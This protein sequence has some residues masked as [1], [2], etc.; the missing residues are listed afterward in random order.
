MEALSQEL[1]ELCSG[2][3]DNSDTD[4]LEPNPLMKE[5]FEVLQ[6]AEVNTTKATPRKKGSSI[7]G[8]SISAQFKTSLIML[9]RQ[10]NAGNPHYVRCIKPNRTKSPS[11]LHSRDV[12]RQLR[13]SGMMEAI[14]IRHEG[15]ALRMDH[16]DFLQEY[17]VLGMGCEDDHGGN[18]GV[19]III[20][21][22][23]IICI[24]L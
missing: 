24:D 1:K 18:M 7:R 22:V 9:N 20:S 19:F 2:N 23:I 4:P 15:Y 10:L 16:R 21:F 12:L 5:M 8:V 13:Y 3:Y 6:P 11:T 17:R 14:R